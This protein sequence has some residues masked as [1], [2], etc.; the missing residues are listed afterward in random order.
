VPAEPGVVFDASALVAYAQND[1]RAFP[2]DELI[3]VMRDD[4]HAPAHIPE[5]ALV[6][7]RV[8]LND[9]K[10]ALD[11]LEAFVAEHGVHQVSGRDEQETIQLIVTKS[12][13]S[14][15][16]AHAMLLTILTSSSLATYAAPTLERAGYEMRLVLDLDEFFRPQ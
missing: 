9:D 8:I 7:A 5:F 15:G 16:M 6:D 13:V 4:T 10:A 2:V 12:G 1:M 14:W 3:A 11:R